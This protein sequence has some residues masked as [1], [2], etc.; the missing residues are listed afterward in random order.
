MRIN[1]PTTG[2]EKP[3]PDE[4]V[5]VSKTD[6]QGTI[7]YCNSD[8]I[9]I[10]GFSQDELIGQPHNL[11]RHPDMPPEAFKDLW[12]TLKRGEPWQ[13]IVK[14]RCKKGDHYWVKANVSPVM[15]DGQVH[16]YM[17]VRTKAS[18]EEIKS[19]ETF[20]KAVKNKTA[21]LEPS[22]LQ[23]LYARIGSIKTTTWLYAT[24]LGAMSF[25]AMIAAMVKAGIS[26]QRL[27]STLGFGALVTLLLGIAVTQRVRAPLKQIAYT[28]SQLAEGRYFDWIETRRCDEFGVLMRHIKNTQVRLGFDVM[29]ARE[30]AMMAMR[31]KRALDNVN[32]NVMMADAENTIIYLNA[33]VESMFK[34]A[35]ADIRQDLPSFQADQLLG[36]NIDQF[37]KNPLHQQRMIDGMSGPIES[38]FVIG[39]R[40]MRFLASPIFG[41]EGERIGT[42]V[43][44]EDRT[45]EVHIEQEISDIVNA[46]VQGQL[47]RR[48]D[49]DGKSGFFHTL[50]VGVNDILAT[51]S[52][53]FNDINHTMSRV[54]EGDLSN[55]IEGDYQG[56]FGDVQHN[57]NRT[58]ANLSNIVTDIRGAADIIRT[59]AN[60]ILSGNNN[61]SARTEQQASGLEQTAASME[62]L[63][64]TVRNNAEN[65]HQADQLAIKA[66]EMAEQGGQVVG[67]AI[68][69]MDE[70]NDSSEKIAEIIGVID[71]IA[72]QTNLLSLNASVEAARAGEQ[73]RGFAVVATEVRNLAQRSATAAKEIKELIQDSGHKVQTGSRLVNESGRTLEDIVVGVKKVGDIIAE[74]AVAGQEQKSGIDQVNQA[75]THMDE[76]TQQN[77][78]LAEETSAASI[79]M[80]ERAEELVRL[81]AFFNVGHRA[82]RPVE[83]VATSEL[84]AES[85]VSQ[86]FEDKVVQ[87]PAKTTEA[88]GNRDNHLGDETDEWEE[89]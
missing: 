79:S 28:L 68:Q 77:A 14:N 56:Q 2:I 45:E 74:I 42:V 83:P 86:V 66:R 81:V 89:F 62:E 23:R 32:A 25:Q 11:V 55:N 43:E 20:Y 22:L 71:E 49:I 21:H 31:D 35:E 47:D 4:T 75:V 7:T 78:A 51:L 34:D 76:A 39:G 46:A 6:K 64:G 1:E 50:S 41:S 30:T 12:Q 73:G 33:A 65:A 88:S 17:S 38:G 3:V 53:T 63:A 15:K 80:N 82:D 8:F 37:H 44:W 9:K 59:G 48:I 29:D 57:I 67:D 72:F 52:N 70:I 24:V 40:T 84:P 60:E 19:A 58:I 18:K 85:P 26:D 61:L 13:G 87:E 5:L 69:A 36:S 54:A 10:S 27:F 16:E